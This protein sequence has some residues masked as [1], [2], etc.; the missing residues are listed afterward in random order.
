MNM[1]GYFTQIDES[2]IADIAHYYNVLDSFL[3]DVDQWEARTP[4]ATNACRCILREVARGALLKDA[5]GYTD[6]TQRKFNE[7]FRKSDTLRRLYDDA[8]ELRKWALG[9]PCIFNMPPSEYVDW[10]E[11]PAAA[12]IFAHQAAWLDR[13]FDEQSTFIAASKL[14][15]ADAQS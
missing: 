2:K 10:R 15:H 5:V 13:W 6:F 1:S 8:Q 4:E 7:R 3:R 12:R 9:K 14:M 11:T